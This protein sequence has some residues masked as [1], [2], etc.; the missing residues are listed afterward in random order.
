MYRRSLSF[1]MRKGRQASTR[2]NIG[3]DFFSTM[4]LT[5]SPAHERL[6][7]S[8]PDEAL[9]SRSG[10]GSRRPKHSGYRGAVEQVSAS[11]VPVINGN[12][13]KV[14]SGESWVHHWIDDFANVK[15][16]R[17]HPKLIRTTKGVSLAEVNLVLTLTR[18]WGTSC[19]TCVNGRAVT[20]PVC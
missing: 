6:R 9:P 12:V 16:Q 17:P 13:A 20:T 2:K 4:F 7:A 3:A 10:T 5:W 8:L 18:L 1:H 11:R 15:I 19:R 14:G